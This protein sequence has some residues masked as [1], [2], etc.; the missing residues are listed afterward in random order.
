MSVGTTTTA[1]ASPLPTWLTGCLVATMAIVIGLGLG[2]TYLIYSIWK[3]S[4]VTPVPVAS[5][6]E[7]AMKARWKSEPATFRSMAA[8]IRAGSLKGDSASLGAAFLAGQDDANSKLEAAVQVG[9]VAANLEKI[10]TAQEA[11]LKG[12]K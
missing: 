11:I 2:G 1:P 9:D 8:A 7:D 6:V 12:V 5:T 3:V 4:G 10:A